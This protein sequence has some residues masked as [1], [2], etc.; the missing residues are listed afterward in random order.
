MLSDRSRRNNK[1]P[2]VWVSLP[3]FA[4]RKDGLRCLKH[5]HF[6]SKQ[7]ALFGVELVRTYEFKGVQTR[8]R[9]YPCHAFSLG[10]GTFKPFAFS[11]LRN[12]T[13]VLNPGQ[14]GHIRPVHSLQPESL[15]E[16]CD[17]PVLVQIVQ[18]LICD[19]ISLCI[20][21]SPLH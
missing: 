12:N 10:G 2:S 9:S 19:S 3:K 13:K 4:I 6:I 20:S 8:F 14:H 15:G 16:F 5:P 7:E 21:L 17:Q 11:L 1:S 18:A